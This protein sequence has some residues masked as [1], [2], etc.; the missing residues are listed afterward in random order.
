MTSLRL[1]LALAALAIIA[2]VYVIAL[3]RKLG[4]ADRDW[5]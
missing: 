5:E 3:L 4:A 2:L 1:I